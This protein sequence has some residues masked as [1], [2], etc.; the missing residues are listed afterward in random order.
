MAPVSPSHV[1]QAS[2]VKPG[3]PGYGTKVPTSRVGP[4]DVRINQAYRTALQRIVDIGWGHDGRPTGCRQR[5]TARTTAPHPSTS[6]QSYES[7][8]GKHMNKKIALGVTAGICAFGAVT[9]SASSLGGVETT[10]LGTSADVVASCDT[11][12]VAVDYTTA[13]SNGAYRVTAVKLSGIAAAC[14]GQNVTATLFDGSRRLARREGRRELRSHP[15]AHAHLPGL[16]RGGRGRGRRHRRLS[17]DAPARP[18]VMPTIP[19]P[20]RRHLPR[21]PRCRSPFRPARCRAAPPGRPGGPRGVPGA[22]LGRRPGA[23]RG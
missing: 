9:A 22:R 23:R 2:D 4:P 10:D 5:T 1:T 11:D 14:S 21:R 15:D 8:R 16:R 6:H 12:G 7:P 19:A 18:P 20:R 3:T 17:R 13:F